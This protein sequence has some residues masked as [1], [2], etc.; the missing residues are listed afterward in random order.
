MMRV[1]GTPSSVFR[2]QSIS[3]SRTFL[4]DLPEVEGMEAYSV[5]KSSKTIAADI[6]TG[7]A[8]FIIVRLMPYI[9][10]Q[11]QDIRPFIV[12][13]FAA[14][15][16]AALARAGSPPK[17]QSVLTVACGGIIPGIALRAAG[18]SLT[19]NVFFVSFLTAS[20]V[21]VGGGAALRQLSRT[22]LIVPL[23]AASVITLLLVPLA[24]RVV[25]RLLDERA[26][27]FVDLH[28]ARFTLKTLDGRTLDSEALRGHVVVASFW[29]TW[30]LPCQ[31]ELPKLEAVAKQYRGNPEVMVVAIDSGT[32]GDTWDK[33][34]AYASRKG[35]ALPIAIDSP[36][37]D[38]TGP[39]AQSLSVPSLP[40][41][42]VL[43]KEGDLRVIHI[44]Y[45]ASEDLEH[46]LK[47]QI[48]HLL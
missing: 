37:G 16:V 32:E 11:H 14:F 10:G 21:G 15:T 8:A 34:R 17:W 41:L 39:A 44:G 19:A 6:A 7:L 26:Y 5:N 29:A 23:G 45:E 18:I 28:V 36:D 24:Y 2:E 22:L 4:K 46:S 12:T 1:D 9:T 38:S 48:D 13:T 35:L 33:V 40:A 3:L 42:Y 25:P 31:E 30:C 43:D 47:M 27:K 20:I